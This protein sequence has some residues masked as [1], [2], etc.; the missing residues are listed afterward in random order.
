MP[1]NPRTG[2]PIVLVGGRTGENDIYKQRPDHPEVFEKGPSAPE[3]ATAAPP[4]PPDEPAPP[5][6]TT[7]A[8]PPASGGGGGAPPQRPPVASKPPVTTTKPSSPPVAAPALPTLPRVVKPAPIPMSTPPSQLA[9]PEPEPLP[10][11]VAPRAH[12]PLLGDWSIPWQEGMP[13]RYGW[14]RRY[15]RQGS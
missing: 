1:I 7:A 5:P 9:A 14:Y 4:P 11:P 6:V 15:D 13:D 10:P 8:P 2:K 12:D 3:P